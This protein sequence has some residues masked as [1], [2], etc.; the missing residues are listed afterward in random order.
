[1][2]VVF[3]QLSDEPNWNAVRVMV[4]ENLYLYTLRRIFAADDFSKC[5]ADR[6]IEKISSNIC[7]EVFIVLGITL[8]VP[9]M[10]HLA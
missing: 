6:M 8:Y 10:Y 5:S 4:K 1:M 9:V 3:F 7:T 2:Q